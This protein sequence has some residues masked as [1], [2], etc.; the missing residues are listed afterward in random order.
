[1]GARELAL[2]SVAE[3]GES[4]VELRVLPLAAEE[5]REAVA[6]GQAVARAAEYVAEGL[7]LVTAKLAAWYE[8]R[9]ATRLD[10]ETERMLYGATA[11]ELAAQRWEAEW[12]R[13]MRE[14]ARDC[15]EVRDWLIADHPEIALE[16]GLVKPPPRPAA[17]PP[18]AWTTGK[19]GIPL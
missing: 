10:E 7:S 16:L 3:A 11:R 14:I 1:M 15:A 13:D 6:V 18:V 12:Q 4:F 5:L 17:P 8:W 9:D 2:Q 19:G